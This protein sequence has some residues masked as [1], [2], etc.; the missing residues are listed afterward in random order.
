MK[1]W[2][3]FLCTAGLAFALSQD[4]LKLLQDPGGWQFITVRDPDSGIQTTHTCF[5]GRPHPDECSGT[6][7]F[8]SDG[9]FTKNI[10]IHH[11][12]VQRHGNYK[13][14]GDQLAFHD[15]FGTQDG[16]YTVAVDASKK[17]MTLD[18]PQIHI[19]LELESAYRKELR[20]KYPD[21]R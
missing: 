4:E 19:G 16:P 20:K 18:M 5:D 7:K 21:G 8:R 15:E 11:Q 6:L 3:P 2:L 12:K 14:D 9:T 13:V 17:T 1:I 10:Y